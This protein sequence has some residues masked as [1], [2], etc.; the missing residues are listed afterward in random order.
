MPLS[1]EPWTVDRKIPVALIITLV[2]QT[3]GILYWAAGLEHRVATVEAW[4]ETNQ[5]TTTRLVRVEER[6]LSVREGLDDLKDAV[7]QMRN[8]G[9]GD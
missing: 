3:A 5:D 4:I 9:P 2:L 8:D 1:N 7:L 6:L